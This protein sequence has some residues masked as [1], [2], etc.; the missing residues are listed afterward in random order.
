M[1]RFHERIVA[2]VFVVGLLF[3]AATVA[4]A[5]AYEDALI[6]FTTDSLATPPTQSTR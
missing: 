3:A 5:G 6:G 1:H 2:L 4:N